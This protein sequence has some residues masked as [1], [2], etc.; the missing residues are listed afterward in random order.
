MI[1][2]GS[3]EEA[4]TSGLFSQ[5]GRTVLF[6]C[7]CNNYHNMIR[8]PKVDYGLFRASHSHNP[9]AIRIFVA[10]S[11]HFILMSGHAP[12]TLTHLQASLRGFST[13]GVVIIT[14]LYMWQYGVLLIR[15]GLFPAVFRKAVMK[16][17]DRQSDDIWHL[18]GIVVMMSSMYAVRTKKFLKIV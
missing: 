3:P 7:V 9:P 15:Q 16:T 14:L 13:F 1:H 12:S 2:D 10:H 17:V 4:K 18:N 8:P 6:S 5:A 11:P